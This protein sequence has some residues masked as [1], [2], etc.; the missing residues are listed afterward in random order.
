MHTNKRVVHT[1][2]P[3]RPHSGCFHP[4]CSVHTTSPLTEFQVLKK[5]QKCILEPRHYS[6]HIHFSTIGF[7]L[8]CNCSNNKKNPVNESLF[9][10]KIRK[11]HPYPPPPTTLITLLWTDSGT[12]EIVCHQLG[13]APELHD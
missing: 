13:L 10:S 4:V 1:N 11:L 9:E 3:H 8:D 2:I 7:L 12:F 5:H 6:E